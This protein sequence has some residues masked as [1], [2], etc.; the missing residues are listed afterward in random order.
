MKAHTPKNFVIQLGSLITLYVSITALV[1]LLFGIIN[2]KFPDE[3]E[4]YGTI[5]GI[6]EGMRVGIAMLVVFFPTY[7]VLTRMSNQNRRRDE[8]GEYT[9]LT[10]WLVYLSLLI[11]SGVVLGDLVTIII[12]FLNGEIT[13]RFILKALA[14]L[15][16]VGIALYYYILDARGRFKDNEKMS[17]QIGLVAA[18]FVAV[19][20][21]Y[22]F[23]N[24]ETPT[25]VREMKLDD[26]QV[27]DLQSI[28]WRVEEYYRLN[29][30]L[31]DSLTDVYQNTQIPSAPTGRMAYEY[32]VVDETSYE[33]CAEFLHEN[34]AGDNRREVIYP[35]E[36]AGYSWDHGAGLSCFKRVVETTEETPLQR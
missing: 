20:V 5:E 28:Q 3:L 1:I 16:V 36:K 4:Y 30:V 19:T 2:I 32:S 29:E 31:P 22:G 34:Q 12:Y 18:I 7:L 17:V 10:K 8:G 25:A 14:L 26:Q 35:L 6:R 33:L 27:S 13:A 15:I 9:S 24:I 21:V 23:M 11:G